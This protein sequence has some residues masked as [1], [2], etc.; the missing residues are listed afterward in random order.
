M[1]PIWF[2]KTSNKFLCSFVFI[3]NFLPLFQKARVFE[4]QNTAINYAAPPEL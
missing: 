3:K 2:V 4:K 1:I